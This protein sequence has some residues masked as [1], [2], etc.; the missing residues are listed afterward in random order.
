MKTGI[1]SIHWRVNLLTWTI[2]SLLEGHSSSRNPLYSL[3]LMIGKSER[4]FYQNVISRSTFTNTSPYQLSNSWKLLKCPN[5]DFERQ[6]S[7]WCRRPNE[8]QTR[9]GYY[10]GRLVPVRRLSDFLPTKYFVFNRQSTKYWKLTIRDC[11][12]LRSDIIFGRGWPWRTRV[13]KYNIT[14]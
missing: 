13:I 6:I 4:L 10:L 14:F 3:L 11:Q 8:C 5:H 7:C 9:R 2:D 12:F 1:Y